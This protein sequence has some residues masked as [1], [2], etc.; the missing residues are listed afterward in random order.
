M[1]R[2]TKKVDDALIECTYNLTVSDCTLE[3]VGK[4][5]LRAENKWGDDSSN[6][7]IYL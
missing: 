7:N 3:D 1:E 2:S 6:V 5:T 4:Y